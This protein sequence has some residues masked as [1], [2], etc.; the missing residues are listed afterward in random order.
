MK[1]IALRDL[2]NQRAAGELFEA[3]D[4]QARV[5]ILLGHA[6]P[7]DAIDEAHPHSSRAMTEALKSA[8]GSRRRTYQ[9]R[10]LTAESPSTED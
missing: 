2:P 6:T 8:P 9:R 7:A 3:P 4:D 10:D 1:V 5:L